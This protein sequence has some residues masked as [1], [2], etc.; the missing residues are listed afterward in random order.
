MA[1]EIVTTSVSVPDGTN[2]TDAYKS[3]V[4]AGEFDED[5]AQLILVQKMDTLLLGLQNSQLA[6]KQSALG[7]LFSSKRSTGSKN[8]GLY[9]WG[10]VGRGKTM[11]MD[12]F[13]DQVSGIKKRRVHFHDFMQD[14]HSKIHTH[15]QMLKRGET[16]ENDPLP[17]VARAIANDTQLLCFDEFSVTDVADA[18]ILSR[19]FTKLFEHGVIVVATS[20]VA[21]EAQYPHGL[22][23]QFFMS[24][25][26]LFKV[27]VDTFWLDARTDFRLEKLAR[28]TVYILTS[29]D[30]AA[31]KLNKLWLEL[32]GTILGE[33]ETLLIK[34]RHVNVPQAARGAARFTFDALCAQPLGAGDYLAIA[35]QYHSVFI[36][37]LPQMGLDMRNEAKRFIILV[38][39]LYD[40]HVNL[41]CTA[42]TEPDKL[43]TATS[44]VEH[45]EFTRTSSRLIEMQSHEYLEKSRNLE[46]K[47]N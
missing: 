47:Q 30:D 13:F 42:E 38:D 41:L 3:R 22:N 36:D 10:S 44:G 46:H 40:N 9:I 15:R 23:R 5:P 45:F 12:M 35:S 20:N 24:F 4:E 21:I 43:Y 33:Q 11:L 2:L 6:S 31:A 34:G 19:L 37:D 25:I 29:T 14:V 1:I 28:A 26:E 27:N 16:N 39:T 32:T 8:R 18:M 17:P 7:W